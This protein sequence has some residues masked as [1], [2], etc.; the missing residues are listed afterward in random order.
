MHKYGALAFWDYATAA[1][2]VV[3]DMNPKPAGDD[4]GLCRKD[5]IFFSMHKVKDFIKLLF[6]FLSVIFKKELFCY[7]DTVQFILKYLSVKFFNLLIFLYFGKFIG[8]VQTPGVLVVKKDVLRQNVV[9]AGGGGGGAVFFVTE[10]DHRFLKEGELREEA[11][12]P[13]I[14]ESIRA[15]THSNRNF[16]FQFFFF[17]IHT[18]FSQ[19]SLQTETT[20]KLAI[21]PIYLSRNGDATE[22]SGWRKIHF[23]S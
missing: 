3:V 9:P 1:P 2:Y 21:S 18:Q 4:S 16:S 13:A 23:D 11:G 8:G 6:N 5:A 14:V 12:T 22:E 15:G 10:S 19:S 20:F 7:L 17:T